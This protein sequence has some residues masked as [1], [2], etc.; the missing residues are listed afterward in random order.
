MYFEY[1]GIKHQNGTVIVP[2]SAIQMLLSGK[3]KVGEESI[4]CLRKESASSDIFFNGNIR[5]LQFK[6]EELRDN[7]E[8]TKWLESI[9]D[10]LSVGIPMIST[11]EDGK[12]TFLSS[13]IYYKHDAKLNCIFSK[14]LSVENIFRNVFSTFLAMAST[15]TEHVSLFA[16]PSGKTFGVSLFNRFGEEVATKE[17]SFKTTTSQDLD[18]WIFEN[19]SRFFPNKIK[20]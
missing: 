2:F 11:D 20:D 5:D 4:P 1:T 9:A 12:T 13:D 7:P 19:A 15:E 14:E 16:M 6:P 18:K 3:M 8:E 10:K 17:M